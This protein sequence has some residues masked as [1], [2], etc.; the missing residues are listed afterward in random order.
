MSLRP[1][2]GQT[3]AVE[4]QEVVSGGDQAPFRANRR[5]TAVFEAPRA[6]VLLD[7]GEDGLDHHL[8]AGVELLAR[9]ALERPSHEVVG[10]AEAGLPR[11]G[12]ALGIGGDQRGDAA[13]SERVDVLV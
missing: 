11:P 12:A 6:S 4:L 10:P 5:P 3:A 13:L 8:A 2:P 1:L 7:V 9:G